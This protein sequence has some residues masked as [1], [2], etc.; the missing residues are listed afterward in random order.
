M[1]QDLQTCIPAIANVVAATSA[2]KGVQSL[3][4]DNAND[5]PF[6]M[7]YLLEGNSGN[8]TSQSLEDLDNIA[9][10]ILVPLE[11]GLGK[12]FPLL[13]AAIDELKVDLVK[14]VTNDVGHQGGHFSFSIDTFQD[15]QIYFLPEYP[16]GNV[17]MIGYR[18]V[19]MQ[20]KLIQENF[21]Q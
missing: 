20:V 6:A 14:E 2:I 4:M 10:D 19:I 5:Y 9:I 12:C 11:W 15:L 16:Y 17:Q 8:N 1:T 21:A 3:P 13:N 7:V 18:I